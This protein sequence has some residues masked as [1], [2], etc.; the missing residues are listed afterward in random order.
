MLA[1]YCSNIFRIFAKYHSL[2]L[3]N[4]SWILCLYPPNFCW[5]SLSF[6][7]MYFRWTFKKFYPFFYYASIR[8]LSLGALFWYVFSISVALSLCM[9]YVKHYPRRKWG[10]SGKN[11]HKAET[12]CLS[13]WDNKKNFKNHII[14]SIITSKD[15]LSVKIGKFKKNKKIFK[16]MLLWT[17]RS[18]EGAKRIQIWIRNLQT[19]ITAFLCA[20]MLLLVHRSIVFK[21]Y[22]FIYFSFF[23]HFMGFKTH[24]MHFS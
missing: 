2:C 16:T 19:K 17:S 7:N 1:I 14:G 3:L 8:S 23:S 24:L 20:C 10:E 22:S 4:F 13:V 9:M 18:E 21:I 11:E 12:N 6:S 5:I 15:S